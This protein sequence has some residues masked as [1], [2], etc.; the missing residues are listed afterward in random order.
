M[1]RAIQITS[2]LLL[3]AALGLLAAWWRGVFDDSRVLLRHGDGEVLLL[4]FSPDGQYLACA[5]YGAKVVVWDV[6]LQK[7]IQT[8]VGHSDSIHGLSFSRDGSWLVTSCWDKTV[9]IW[10]T[11]KWEC[12]RT[13]RFPEE[14]I[15]LAITPD[16]RSLVAGLFMR[17]RHESDLV[18]I[19]LETGAVEQTL[20][21]GEQD[22]DKKGYIGPLGFT[23]DGNYLVCS[24]D[25]PGSF[26][27]FD[28]L[29]WKPIRRISGEGP[30]PELGYQGLAFPSKGTVFASAGSDMRF[31]LWD[32]ATGEH[33]RLIN[34]DA[35]GGIQGVALSPDS[36]YLVG[37]YSMD[38]PKLIIWEWKTKAGPLTF[39]DRS[40]PR[41]LKN[42]PIAFSPDGEWLAIGGDGCVLLKRFESILASA[43]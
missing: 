24:H 3:L 4:A 2:C 19:N 28:A 10:R 18:V 16:S 39:H 42:A 36:R 22:T 12:H 32:A 26:V 17:M 40:F 43:R 11:G 31:R 6:H 35:Y 29:T 27:L 30:L 13:I 9:R 23:A 7:R 41:A 15:R 5:V 37:S 14:R 20:D 1:R 38:D 21:L 8:L 34:P 25:N 33:T